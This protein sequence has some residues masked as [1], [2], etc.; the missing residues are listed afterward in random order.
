MQ[1]ADLRRVLLAHGAPRLHVHDGSVNEE[2][3]VDCNNCDR[4]DLKDV[5]PDPH[6]RSFRSTINV[7]CAWE[8]LDDLSICGRTRPQTL[9][10]QGDMCE[11]KGAGKPDG[12][13]NSQG[14]CIAIHVTTVDKIR[15]QFE[16]AA[17]SQVAWKVHREAIATAWHW[18]T[19]VGS[20][21]KAIR[22][23]AAFRG[24]IPA[25]V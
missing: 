9:G 12:E 23:L 13:T 16:C 1:L 25:L 4:N 10:N 6:K 2:R 17:A 20:I 24:C 15:M 14:L 3:C 8:D 22:E 7:E 5:R 21:L 19:I 18:Q 11:R